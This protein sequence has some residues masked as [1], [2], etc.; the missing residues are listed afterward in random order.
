M[1]YNLR[2]TEISGAIGMHQVDRIE[3]FVQ[4]RRKN[5]KQWCEMVNRLSLPIRVYP[6]APNTRHAGFAFPMMLDADAPITRAQLCAQLE[7][8]Q[9]QTRPI[10]G[11]NLAIQP[12]FE[13]VPNKKIRGPL[14][15]ATAVQERGFFVGQSHCFTDAHGE[16]LCTAL[17]EIF[18]S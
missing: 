3:G 14:S 16:L 15:V 5:H 4:Q 2:M 6:E 12:A 17:K 9:I 8:R 10:S 13:K 1:G 11:A 18:A 7:N